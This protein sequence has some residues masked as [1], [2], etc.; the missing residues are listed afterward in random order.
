MAEPIAVIIRFTGNPEDLF[1]RFEQARQSWI[2]T[3]DGDYEP[4][5]FYAACRADN[6]I[7]IISAWKS[8]LAHRAFGQGLH[9]HIDAVGLGAPG[10]IE[11]MR[12][13]RL[14]WE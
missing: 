8:A 6:G 12:I 10:Q 7:A 13:D 11:R 1:E 3:Q 9:A 2:G 5:V 14:G 4:P